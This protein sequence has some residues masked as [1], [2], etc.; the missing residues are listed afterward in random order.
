MST[1][2]M[3]Y[4]NVNW[5]YNIHECQLE[6]YTRRRIA[7]NI[8]IQLNRLFLTRKVMQLPTDKNNKYQLLKK[9]DLKKK[10]KGLSYSFQVWFGDSWPSSLWFNVSLWNDAEADSKV[11]CLWQCCW[12][13]THHIYIYIASF[14][15]F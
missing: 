8:S 15:W 3:I 5:N 7:C 11:R 1:G 12:I 4:R 10:Q 9:S 14:P 2:T 6:L 13:H